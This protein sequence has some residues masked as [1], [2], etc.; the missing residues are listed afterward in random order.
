MIEK[1]NSEKFMQEID[2]N[3]ILDVS[4]LTIE[5]QREIKA[6]VIAYRITNAMSPL[7][8]ELSDRM[9]ELTDW[10]KQFLESAKKI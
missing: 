9:T 3:N 8:K 6:K 2:K 4:D 1:M 10:A 5:Q 7:M